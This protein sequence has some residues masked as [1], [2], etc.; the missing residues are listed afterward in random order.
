ML[1]GT[2]KTLSNFVL[3]IVTYLSDTTLEAISKIHFIRQRTLAD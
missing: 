1:N 3:N 2:R